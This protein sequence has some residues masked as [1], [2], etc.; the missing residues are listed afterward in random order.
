LGKRNKRETKGKQKGNK[1]EGNN[2]F[3]G[4]QRD[5]K[6]FYFEVFQEINFKVTFRST[7][8]FSNFEMGSRFSFLSYQFF[9]KEKKQR[10]HLFRKIL[11]SISV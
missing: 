1:W 11:V 10:L 5:K 8:F 9:E 3:F 6:N 7:G 2:L 4:G